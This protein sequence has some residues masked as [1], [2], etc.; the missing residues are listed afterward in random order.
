MPSTIFTEVICS[1]IS[2]LYF[3]VVS[4]KFG[5]KWKGTTAGDKKGDVESPLCVAC[6][7]SYAGRIWWRV[8]PSLPLMGMRLTDC[9]AVKMGVCIEFVQTGS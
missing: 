8:L 2:I 9:P 6:V 4:G 1:V 7:V 3:I 5:G